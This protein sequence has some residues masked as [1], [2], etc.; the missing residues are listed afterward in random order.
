ML[1]SNLQRVIEI[2]NSHGFIRVT[3]VKPSD[4]T[5]WWVRISKATNI[6]NE[7]QAIAYNRDIEV[8]CEKCLIQFQELQEAYKK[9]GG[10]DLY[11]WQ[12]EELKNRG[13][14]DDDGLTPAGTLKL[15]QL[16]LLKWMAQ[17][18]HYE[19]QRLVK[20]K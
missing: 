9:A 18:Y 5:R 17:R 1:Q 8:A 10:K 19:N 14:A 16:R 15:H 20:N 3:I 4:D 6:E 11:P 12:I 7:Y 13:L 2:G